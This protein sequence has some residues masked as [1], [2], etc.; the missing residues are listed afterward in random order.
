MTV[1]TVPPAAGAGPDAADVRRPKKQS[2]VPVVMSATWKVAGMPVE[3]KVLA[4]N[5][6]LTRLAMTAAL[7][8]VSRTIVLL[9]ER[10]PESSISRMN[11][12]A[13]N[14]PVKITREALLVLRTGLSISGASKRAFSLTTG[15]LAGLWGFA[16]ASV[17]PR[18]PSAEA[19]VRSLRTVDDTKLI[20]DASGPSATLLQPGTTVSAEGLLKGYAIDRALALLRTRGYRDALVSVDGDVGAI[21]SK[22][23]EPWLVGIQDPGAEGHFALLPLANRSIATVGD[24]QHFFAVA[25][26]RYHD[27]LD[28][29]TG[30]PAR[31]FRSVTIIAG[32]TVTADALARAAFVL[33]PDAAMDFVRSRGDADAVF[34][35]GR[36][37]VVVSERLK[38]RLRVIRSPSPSGP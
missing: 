31:G 25:A 9:S 26:E 37:Q 13:G 30:Q 2:P 8:D 24:Y 7:D 28:P 18:V 4:E 12:G 14:G 38:E 20:L 3:V 1:A 34:V 35:D 33:G 19:I 5:D 22:G 23:A 6:A 16:D 27:L 11:R 10:S 36:N 21:G 29:R 15:A 32:D 17:S